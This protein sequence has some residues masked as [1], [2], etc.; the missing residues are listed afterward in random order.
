MLVCSFK[1]M[2][3]T[4]A[5]TLET[6]ATP[7]GLKLQQTKTTWNIW[8]FCLW[9]SPLCFLVAGG[10]RWPVMKALR[11]IPTLHHHLL[12][13]DADRNAGW[14]W[15]QRFYSSVCFSV[16]YSLWG[17]WEAAPATKPNLW[18]CF[19]LRLCTPIW[20]HCPSTVASVRLNH[21][22]RQ[23]TSP[24]NVNYID[25]HYIYNVVNNMQCCVQIEDTYLNRRNDSGGPIY[26]LK[27]TY[28]Q[29]M[30]PSL[31]HRNGKFVSS[32]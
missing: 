18:T 6:L 7:A 25:I 27:P 4:R 19:P 30:P 12:L 10:R 21:D 32:V 3:V 8:V 13:T 16:L 22:R 23:V 2:P 15:L 11:F 26:M 28:P 20:H 9:F 17:G 5:F 31:L 1:C 14:K 24:V 29:S